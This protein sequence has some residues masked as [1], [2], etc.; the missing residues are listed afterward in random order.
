MKSKIRK[1]VI[2]FGAIIVAVL[3]VLV[4][5]FSLTISKI[6]HAD[7][8]KPTQ[9]GRMLTIYDRGTEKVI[10]TEEATIGEALNKAGIAIDSKDVV[11]P[12]ADQ[13]LIA[14]DYQVNIYRA[15]PVLIIDGNTRTKISTAYQT[16]AQIIESAGIKLYDEDEAVIT[17]TNDI[18]DGVGLQVVIDRAIPVILTLFGRT[19]EIRTQSATV[20]EFLQEK[21]IDLGSNDKVTPDK[22]ASIANGLAIRIWREGKQI[23]SVD[24]SVAFEVETIED[25]DR[26]VG[27][28][29][30][31]TPGENGLRSVSYEAVIQDGVEVSRSEIASI[32]IKKPTIQT[33]LIGVKGKYSTPSENETI[34]WEYLLSQGFSRIQAAGI[35]GNLMQEHGFKTSD[36]AG[37]YG[38]AQW[39]GGRRSKLAARDN[40]DN[41]Y[42]QL[43]FLMSELN[44]GYSY[45]KDAIKSSNSLE[46]VVEIFQNQFE[47]CNPR[48]CML[49]Q[50]VFY[51]QNILANHP[52][53]EKY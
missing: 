14:S 20:A 12:A 48:Y 17:S 51:A 32:L 47:R 31:Q 18:L 52:S 5:V 49:N 35:M 15:R 4:A 44:G 26:S 7:D 3:F 53:N 27:Y 9:P 43:D 29:E 23:I 33:E 30:I 6:T 45:V 40:S 46:A 39:V 13:Q 25:A 36:V 11:E 42:V 19:S 38:I 10:I 22:N 1:S 21:N 41:I 34:T 28:K 24:E 37:G 16:A 50:R 2:P 8:G